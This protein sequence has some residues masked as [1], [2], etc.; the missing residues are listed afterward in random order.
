MRV[1]Q[2]VTAHLLPKVRCT[3]NHQQNLLEP[4]NNA[5]FGETLISPPGTISRAVY[6]K[7]SDKKKT[8]AKRKYD[9]DASGSKKTVHSRNG[10]TLS[11][12]QN[13]Y[14]PSVQMTKEE[15]AKWRLEAR[16]KRNRDSA[17]A[18]RRKVHSKINELE[19]EVKEWKLKYNTLYQKL[20]EME[21]I[22][23]RG[24]SSMES[25]V[26]GK[27]KHTNQYIPVPFEETDSRYTPI[28]PTDSPKLHSCSDYHIIPESFSLGSISPSSS[29]TF[30]HS[31]D[32]VN[33]QHTNE[34]IPESFSLGSMSPSSS[35]TFHHSSDVV[36]NQH[37]NEFVS[38]QA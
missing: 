36:N 25:Q 9:S 20:N 11:K 37:I 7:K 27:G 17:A 30:H 16:K 35:F 12:Y 2:R 3:N 15:E 28:S 10:S 26:S 29:F 13:H 22:M 4:M 33:D 23:K 8:R 31:S 19:N 14:E 1:D 18:S 38:R 34:I 5:K 6:S 21:K 24:N 32:I